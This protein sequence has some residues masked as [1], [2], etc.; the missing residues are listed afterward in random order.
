MG[1]AGDGKSSLIDA[2]LDRSVVQPDPKTGRDPRG[3]T[4]EITEYVVK[5]NG[6]QAILMVCPRHL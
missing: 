2:L 6:M 4:K 5:I 3:V 1:E